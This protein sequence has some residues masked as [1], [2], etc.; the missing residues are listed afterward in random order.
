M[1]HKHNIVVFLTFNNFP[2][3]DAGSVRLIALAKGLVS[4]GYYIKVISMAKKIMS[5]WETVEPGID[6]FSVRANGG[7]IRSAK[8][9]LF[10]NSS[11]NRLL[12]QMS[13]IKA[14]FF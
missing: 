10:F 3:Q 12:S 14:I 1:E 8:S 2:N 5:D 9:Y 7:R 13:G 6:H 11:V 4:S